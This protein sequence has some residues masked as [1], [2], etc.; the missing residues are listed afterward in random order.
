[1]LLY[2]GASLGT[3]VVRPR[4][5]QYNS[6]AISVLA[7]VQEPNA[8]LT[9]RVYHFIIERLAALGHYIVADIVKSTFR[10]SPLLSEYVHVLVCCSGAFTSSKLIFRVCWQSIDVP[11]CVLS[12]ARS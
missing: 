8:P 11:R 9:P 1:M 4:R 5:A 2:P 6:F 10:Y 12:I 3:Y 7:P